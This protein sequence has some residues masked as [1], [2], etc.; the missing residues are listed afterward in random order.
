MRLD[1][2]PRREQ[3][4]AYSTVIAS[5]LREQT[6]YRASLVLDVL[7]SVL[8]AGADLLEVLV[9]FHNVP[10]LG[11]LDLPGAMLVFGVAQLGFST[12]NL[13]AGQ[14]DTVHVHIRTGTLEVLLLRPQPLLAQL[15]TG[16]IMLRR[17]GGVGVGAAV[18]AGGI[19]GSDVNWT[20]LRLALLLSAPLTATGIFMALFVVA[21]AVQFWLVDAPEVTNAF[22]DGSGYA[23]RYPTSVLPGPLQLL[24]ATLVP[25]AFAGY[26]PALALLDVPGPAWLPAWLGWCPALVAVLAWGGA[27]VAWRAGVRHHTGAGG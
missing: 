24:Y 11:G 18:L 2:R 6:A 23:A 12:A 3:L 27:L 4:S 8:I 14:L 21:G 16:S 7:G 15:M 19:A 13:V 9:V 1:M 5:R 25:A 20:P 10:A 17:L 26:L 22:T